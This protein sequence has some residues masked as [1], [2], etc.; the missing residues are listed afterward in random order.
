MRLPVARHALRGVRGAALWTAI[1]AAGMA[2]LVCLIYPAYSEGL[3]DFEVPDFLKGLVGEAGGL[4]SPAGFLSTELFS[5]ITPVVAGLALAWGTAA[6]SEADAGG[7]L[8]PLMVQPISRVRLFAE[9]GAGLAAAAGLAVLA[10]APALLAG[11]ALAGMDVAPAR[12]VAAVAV[13]VPLV[14]LFLALGMALGAALPSRRPATAAGMALLV[15][16]WFANSIGAAIPALEPLRAASPFRWADASIVLL[17]GPEAL[18][19]AGTSAAAAALA[20]VGALLFRRRG[21][22]GARRSHPRRGRLER[23]GAAAT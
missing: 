22:G 4:A 20:V 18:R 16:A 3:R 9:A 13:Q 14:L 12:L 23:R 5:W 7:R 8:E 6:M 17:H 15:A 1:S 21:G 11:A 10:A 2:L 19:P